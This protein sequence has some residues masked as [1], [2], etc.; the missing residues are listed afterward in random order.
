MI[1]L[2][3]RAQDRL[4]RVRNHLDA[5]V[6]V[7]SLTRLVVTITTSPPWHRHLRARRSEAR[8]RVRRFLHKP[9]RK[10]ALRL[11][12]DI[13]LL[14]SHHSRPRLTTVRR[15]MSQWHQGKQWSGSYWGT[16]RGRSGK[17]KQAR[18]TIH[19]DAAGHRT[20]LLLAGTTRG[21]VSETDTSLVCPRTTFDSGYLQELPNNG[22]CAEEY[23][24][25]T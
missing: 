14:E 1:W 21:S 6:S 16:G 7:K 24:D 12:A 15:V 23:V 2:K 22:G 10:G 20:S 11:Q 17:G 9:T 3:C 4:R 19:S 18:D 13:R 8:A 5:P 25:G